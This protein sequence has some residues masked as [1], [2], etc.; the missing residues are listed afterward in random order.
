MMRNVPI[1]ACT[2]LLLGVA[3]CS[4]ATNN[5]TTDGES[6]V[7][8]VPNLYQNN[9]AWSTPRGKNLEP[10]P[11]G[12]PGASGPIGNHPDHPHF[13][14]ITG[15]PTPRIG[16]DTNPLLI[17]WAAD[18]MR[19][20]RESILAGVAPFDPAARCWL[21]GVPGIISFGVAPM[22]FMQTPD[23]VII[24]Y[25]RGQLARHVYLNTEHSSDIELS[26][27]GESIGWYEGDSLVVDTIGLNDKTPIDV[28]NV[29][30]SESL[31]IVETYRVI[32][33]LLHVLITVE[34]PVAFTEVWSAS[35]AFEAGL[36]AMQEV[37]CQEGADNFTEDQVPMP[38]A[39]SADF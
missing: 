32:D 34:D 13:G 29:P 24:L 17:P 38:I 5:A 12:A 20:T 35:K 26:W 31:H 22:Y 6:G 15:M 28:F 18:L 23:E 11:E 9:T 14:N 7:A 27:H 33:G 39:Q 3:A 2:A 21:P 25:E 8:M 36:E 4:Q 30:H 37:V 1:L 19:Q 16:N 10:P